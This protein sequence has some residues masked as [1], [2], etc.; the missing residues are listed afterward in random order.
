MGGE[1]GLYGGKDPEE[2]AVDMVTRT[3]EYFS[4]DFVESRLASA[5]RF[6]TGDSDTVIRLVGAAGS[7][8]ER[9]GAAVKRW[10]AGSG[11]TDTAPRGMMRVR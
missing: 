7:V 1:T 5:T 2:Y 10:A 3:P 4:Q 8:V 11:E 6:R 9:L